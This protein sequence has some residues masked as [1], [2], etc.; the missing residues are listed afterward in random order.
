MVNSA[1]RL[2]GRNVGLKRGREG[3]GGPFHRGFRHRREMVALNLVNPANKRRQVPEQVS[4]LTTNRLSVYLRCLNTL[5]ELGVQ[6]IS[7]QSL[8]ERFHLNAAQIRKDL[9][10][11][12][13]F[14][15]RGVGYY[16]KE[17]RRHLRKILGLDRQLRVAIMGAGNLGLALADYPGFRQEGFEIAALF[18]AADEKIGHE[19]RSG[20]P[21]H[22]IKELRRVARK[23]R[24]D[25]AVIAV[26][27][28]RA[29][30]VVDQVVAAGIKAILNFS[31]GRVDGAVE[32]EAQERGSHGVA[33]EPVVLS[34]AGRGQQWL[35]R[36]RA[37]RRA[38]SCR[39]STRAA[40]RGWWTWAKSRRRAAKPRATGEITMSAAALRLIRTRH[41][42]QRR[43]APD[44]TAGGH[45][46]RQAD[47]RADPAV[48]S[49]RAHPRERRSHA[50]RGA[51]TGS[52]RACGRPGRPASRWRRLTAV[53]VAA[54][55][56]YDM[57][58]AVDKA[59]VIG[60][61]CVLEKSG[62]RS[63][64]YQ[65]KAMTG[66]GGLDGHHYRHR[67]AVILG[68]LTAMGPL[69]ID[70]YL[71][72]L[73]EHRARARR[74]HCRG[75]GEPGQLLHRHRARSGALRSA[76]GSAGTQAGALSRPRD[77]RR[78]V[79]R[80]RL[81]DQ[82]HSAR[83]LSLPAGARRLRAAR[84]AAGRR[85]RLFRRARVGADA[86]DARFS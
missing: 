35:R 2:R 77:L 49:A 44:R 8:A 1:R 81:H 45:H 29:Q 86:V 65:R 42:G 25:I 69:A 60:G 78:R 20:V 76:V 80:L 71:P 37:G 34:G 4:E 31:P 48:P 36:R 15:V 74:A 46:G 6:T 17:L 27:A 3:R 30:P 66:A 24:L 73:P 9:A 53:S 70:M 62:G 85:A 83:R 11:F 21:I 40:R 50:R 72:A 18:D 43:S 38:R 67:L 59:M 47:G 58:K 19:S 52:S 41:G 10:Y 51:A 23:D 28:P 26:P 13:E 64:H 84:G 68:A 82:R 33:R 63:G 55:T 57:V 56:I 54:L 7:S 14:G 39:T 5:D 22:D 16:V 79:A 12:G 61:I 75:A 32:R